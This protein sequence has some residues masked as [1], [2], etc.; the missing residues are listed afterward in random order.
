[1]YSVLTDATDV[2]RLER[3]RRDFVANVSHELRRQ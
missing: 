2:R 1:M 3:I